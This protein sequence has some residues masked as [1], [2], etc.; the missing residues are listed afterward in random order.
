M[1]QVLYST[2]VVPRYWRCQYAGCTVG[3]GRDA[4]NDAAA[5]VMDTGHACIAQVE[6]DE[7]V[8]MLRGCSIA[9]TARTSSSSST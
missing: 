4:N 7:W 1:T 9:R 6:Q 2:L 8:I 3:G 5:H